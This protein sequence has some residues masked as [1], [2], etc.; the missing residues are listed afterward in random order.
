MSTSKIR[1]LLTNALIDGLTDENGNSL[2][3]VKINGFMSPPADVEDTFIVAHIIP[4]DTESDTL[5]GDHK[6]YTG[7]F[8]MMVRSDALGNGVLNAE[9][10]ADKL[11]EIFY[12]NRR[13]S[14]NDFVVQV[15]SPL[16]VG[17]GI[18]GPEGNEWW[19]VPCRFTYRADT[20]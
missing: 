20:N 6:A 1:R 14:D 11:Q 7:I 2:Y 12:I 4:A 10:A 15:T 3:T 19:Q 17:E 5:S 16:R 9:L 13:L 18:Q 8:Q